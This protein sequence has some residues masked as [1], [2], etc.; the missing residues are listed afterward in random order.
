MLTR[1]FNRTPAPAAMHA[2]LLETDWPGG[3]TVPKMDPL[4]MLQRLHGRDYLQMEWLDPQGGYL[5][6]CLLS[7]FGPRIHIVGFHIDQAYQSQGHGRHLLAKMADELA[8]MG[9]NRL[10]LRATKVGRLAW[11]RMG[12]TPDASMYGLRHAYVRH[13]KTIAGSRRYADAIP[14]LR[15]T[16][17]DYM[18]LMALPDVLSDGTRLAGAIAS[19]RDY[20]FGTLDLR[21]SDNVRHLADYA[22]ANFRHL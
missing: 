17:R 13:T 16:P 19:S 3:I 7:F 12:F 15:T 5:G 6:W 2:R 10:T 20:W 18:D 11:A 4:D 8:G 9:V 21:N 14:L 1:L 22:G